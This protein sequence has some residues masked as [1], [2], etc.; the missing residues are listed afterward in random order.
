[1]IKCLPP[2]PGGCPRVAPEKF[3]SSQYTPAQACVAPKA[4]VSTTV[5]NRAPPLSGCI[6]RSLNHKLVPD[7]AAQSLPAVGAVRTFVPLLSRDS[8]ILMMIAKRNCKVYLAVLRTSTT[9][10]AEVQ[11]IM[12]IVSTCPRKLDLL[13]KNIASSAAVST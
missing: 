13:E 9:P 5:L 4:T 8:L 6:S 12:L 7:R 1:M 10:V 3:Q 2:G 11:A